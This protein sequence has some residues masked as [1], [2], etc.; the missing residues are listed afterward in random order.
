MPNGSAAK[1]ALTSAEKDA[2]RA[3]ASAYLRKVSDAPQPQLSARERH[4]NLVWL[5]FNK[6][7]R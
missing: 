7:S 2:V 6:T 1:E 5:D 4:D 3:F